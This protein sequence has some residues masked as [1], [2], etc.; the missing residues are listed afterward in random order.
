MTPSERLVERMREF[1]DMAPA[2]QQAR[3]YGRIERYRTLLSHFPHDRRTA[4]T[5]LS[6]IEELETRLARSR[7]S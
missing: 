7:S 4:Q 5:L 6:E 3:L 2:K 1:S